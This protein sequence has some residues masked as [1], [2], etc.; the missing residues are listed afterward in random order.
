MTSTTAAL[1][2]RGSR[3]SAGDADPSRARSVPNHKRPAAR[4]ASSHPG[5]SVLGERGG[6]DV[7]TCIPPLSRRECLAR[8]TPGALSHHAVASVSRVKRETTE[9]DEEQAPARARSEA[10]P[11][12]HL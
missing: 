8:T 10:A 11:L 1:V 7:A 9:M 12:L 2:T 6:Q 5:R 4:P 3:R